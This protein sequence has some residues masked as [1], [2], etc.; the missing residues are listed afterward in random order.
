MN[1]CLE[2]WKSTFKRKWAGKYLT[3]STVFISRPWKKA[4]E[5]NQFQNSKITVENDNEIF[6]Y[7]QKEKLKKETYREIWKK[8]QKT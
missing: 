7:E 6:E 4:K 1:S 8:N 5:T 3:I 2:K